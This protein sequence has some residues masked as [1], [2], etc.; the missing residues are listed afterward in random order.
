MLKSSSPRRRRVL[1]PFGWTMSLLRMYSPC[2]INTTYTFC[3]ARPGPDAPASMQYV[4]PPAVRISSYTSPT[5]SLRFPECRRT[6]RWTTLASKAPTIAPSIMGCESASARAVPTTTQ[7][8]HERRALAGDSADSDD[9]Q[10]LSAGR[11]KIS[12]TFWTSTH[13]ET[14]KMIRTSAQVVVQ[15]GSMGLACAQDH[16][17]RRYAALAPKR[18]VILSKLA[19]E[20]V[21][22]VTSAAAAK[23]DGME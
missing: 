17:A 10:K 13:A 11:P 4:W 21:D 3:D 7:Q 14:P 9:V 6:S 20:E 19:T 5:S 23:M 22:G 8:T 15:P 2:V 12:G 16:V 1:L 18:K